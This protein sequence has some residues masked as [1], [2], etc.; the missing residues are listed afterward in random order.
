[1]PRRILEG[2]VVSD[3][4]DKTVTVLVERR[5]KHPMY[6]KYVKR[7]DKYAAHDESNSFKIGDRVQIE[8][9]RPISKRKTWRV[10]TPATGAAKKEAAPKVE[11]KTEAKAEVKEAPKKEEAKKAP[12]K[13]AA[14]KKAPAKKAAAKKATSKKKDDS[15]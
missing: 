2:D 4:M 6:K 9:C 10:I 5:F 15:K 1:M 13:K 12:A 7:T 3:K 8:E 11:A 14:A